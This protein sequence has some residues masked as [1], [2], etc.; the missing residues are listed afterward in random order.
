EKLG[1]DLVLECTGSYKTAQN[2]QPYLKAGVKKVVVSTPAKDPGVLNAVMGVNDGLYDPARHAIVTAA[3]CTTNALAPV[4]K[5]MHEGL[6][7]RQGAV[8]TIHDV[9][10]T[11]T[12]IDGFHKDLR[13]ARSSSVSLI[14]TSTGS[15]KA[16]VE[17]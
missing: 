8:T 3:S 2:L 6:G 17:I 14:P 5:V 16:I 7:I 4:V 1:I 13:R 11:Q 9:T 15:A 12:I 10:N